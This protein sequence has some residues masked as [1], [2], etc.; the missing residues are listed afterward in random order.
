ML[1]AQICLVVWIFMAF[2]FNMIMLTSSIST[3]NYRGIVFYLFSLLS[4]IFLTLLLY[5]TGAFNKVI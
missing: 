1:W 3:K 5:F 4:V 2:I